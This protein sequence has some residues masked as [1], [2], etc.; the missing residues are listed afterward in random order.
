MQLTKRLRDLG[1]AMDDPAIIARTG[2]TTRNLADGLASVR[3]AVPFDLVSLLIGVNN[4]YQGRGLDEYRREF[5]DLLNQAIGYA[6]GAT[7][8]VFVLSIPDWGVTPFAAG[9]DRAA[10]GAA[11]DEFNAA[12]RELTEAAGVAYIDI[13]PVSRQATTNPDLIAYDGLHPSGRM[14]AAWVAAALETACRALQSPAAK[15]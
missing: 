1:Y 6:G 15:P 7:Q 4:Q 12:N 8:R 5:A 14:Y 9:A 10:I 3:L 11:I 13:T 2:W